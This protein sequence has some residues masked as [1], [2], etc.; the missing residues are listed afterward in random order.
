MLG[1]IIVVTVALTL[2]GCSRLGARGGDES[3]VA[4]PAAVSSTSATAVPDA[5]TL[6]EISSD[7]G[8]ADTANTEAG[9]NASAGDQAAA[10]SD[11]R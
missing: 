1:P 5:A 3:T 6:G 11:D 10:T 2:A 4:P 7:L 9:S 8:A